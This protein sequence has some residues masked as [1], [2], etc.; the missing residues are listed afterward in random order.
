MQQTQSPTISLSIPSGALQEDT[1]I[2]YKSIALPEGKGEVIPTQAAYDFQPHGIQFNKPATLKIC[3]DPNQLVKDNIQEKT[4]QISYYDSES[5]EYISMGGEVN[6]TTHCVESSIYHFSNYILTAQVL[7]SINAAPIFI[8]GASFFP[9]TPI[10]GLPATIRTQITDFNT[11]TI[12]NAA[13][14]YRVAGSGSSF[15]SIP[16]NVSAND[17]TTGQFYSAVIP[18]TAFTSVAGIEY[19]IQVFDTLGQSKRLPTVA[20]ATITRTADVPDP[21]TPIR[22]SATVTN[23]TAGFARDLTV[24]VKGQSSATFFPVITTNYSISGNKGETSIPSLTSIRYRAITIGSTSFNATYGNLTTSMPITIL[25]GS[26]NRIEL[27]YNDVAQNN[28]FSIN[29][30][31]THQFDVAGYD[32][33]GNFIYVLPTFSSTPNIGS[34]SAVPANQGQFTALNVNNNVT[35]QFDLNLGI[36]NRSYSV[37]LI[38]DNYGVYL[39]IRNNYPDVADEF[40]HYGIAYSYV[41]NNITTLFPN[42]SPINGLVGT[43]VLGNGGTSNTIFLGAFPNGS[44]INIQTNLFYAILSRE[45]AYNLNGNC[46]SFNGV[47]NSSS[48]SFIS[49]CFPQ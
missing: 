6:F 21:V 12:A 39:T 14:F 32:V 2:S 47:I 24:Q 35:G 3:Y 20:P 28:S 19:Y 34:F 48:I 30:N 10:V 16:L 36:Y 4:L 7:A 11:G 31:T 17:T 45:E 43:R 49:E 33:Y 15:T 27:L 8:G 1:T 25:P 40:S 23:M 46:S 26:L 13:V 44:T 9:A 42:I 29:H 18:E 37:T 38:P 22:F 41:V 5:K